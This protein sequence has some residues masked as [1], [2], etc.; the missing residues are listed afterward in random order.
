MRTFP[1]TISV[2]PTEGNVPSAAVVVDASPDW[3]TLRWS[4][5]NESTAAVTIDAVVATIDL[6]R[7][8]DFVRVA[9]NGYQSWSPTR[10]MLL[11]IDDDPSRHPRSIGFTRFMHHADP[12]VVDARVLRS[13]QVVAVDLGTGEEPF[14]LGFDGGRDHSGWFALRR[15]PDGRVEVAI[16]AWF[17][18][19]ELAAGSTRSLHPVTV[20]Q[21]PDV[22]AQLCA[23]ADRV[24]RAEAAR[25]SAPYQV[26]WCSWYH[27]FHDVTE[28]A[29]RHNLAASDDWPFEVF[30]LDDGFQAHIG[31][32]LVTN[33]KFPSDL[34]T[35]ADAISA[36]GRTPGLWLA[37][38]LASSDAPVFHT[39]PEW[40]ARE[41]AH[42][43][44]PVAGML[45]EHWG[46]LMWQLDTTNPEVLDH[47]ESTARTLREMGYSY[48]KLDFT[49]SPG[50]RGVYHDPAATPA[51]RIRAGYDAIRRG[52][53]DDAFILGCG[54]P[55]GAVVGV[56]DAMRIG[57]DVAPSWEVGPHDLLL[58]G[59]ERVAP[60]TRHA[61]TST[62]HRSYM[63][64][65]L[66]LNDPDC[67]MLR[68]RE[69]ALTPDQARAWALA[70]GLSGGL[71]LVSDDLALLDAE[72]HALLDEVVALGRAADAEAIAGRTPRCDDL[73]DPAGPAHLTA[74][75]RHLVADPADPHPVLS[76]D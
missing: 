68:Q 30:Q 13:E 28:A 8:G 23:W 10:T 60:A 22:D 42:P 11:G 40:F 45:H 75:G 55:L 27:Y 46:G 3:P 19:A 54:A 52:A 47:L 29:L 18:G 17:G 20:T 64:R 16:T 72:S 67:L 66:W 38:F 6:G 70:V 62:L 15:T 51:Q 39:H 65:R 56:V 57:P 31:D 9:V 7:A 41:V 43:E 48:L 53:G 73:L 63:H 76:A 24:G 49:F 69:T 36:A 74:A 26:G 59:L 25:T 37:P 14:V 44:R 21:G 12:G 35:I 5:A 4:V 1:T 50:V 34:A 2:R 32:W 71:A 58:P 61:W 33:D